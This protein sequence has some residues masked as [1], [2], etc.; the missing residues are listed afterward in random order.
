[1]GHPPK[2]GAFG[3]SPGSRENPWALFGYFL[4]LGI[5]KSSAKIY[6]RKLQQEI[7]SKGTCEVCDLAY[8]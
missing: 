2:A 7:S 8:G 1:M 6:G 5:V 4:S 3:R